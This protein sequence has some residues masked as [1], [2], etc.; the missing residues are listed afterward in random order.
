MTLDQVEGSIGFELW[1]D[2]VR[3]T[4]H[5][6]ERGKERHRAVIARAAHQVHI[7][8]VE[9]EDRDDLKHVFDVHAV[10]APCALWMASRAGG[11]D[12]RRT[13]PAR[14]LRLDRVI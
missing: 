13:E 7:R 11:I 3:R 9:P 12:H 4:E 2:D 8:L 5:L 6:V 10:R 14:T 1:L